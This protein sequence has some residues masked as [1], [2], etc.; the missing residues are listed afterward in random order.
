MKK[1]NNNFK[2]MVVV[3]VLPSLI[4]G[5]VEKGTLEVAKHLAMNGHNSIVI[6][7]GG[8][9]VNQLISDG[10]THIK[11]AI[12]KKSILTFFYII[13]LVAL[14]KNKN[15]ANKNEYFLLEKVSFFISRYTSPS[16]N[17]SSEISANPGTLA[18]PNNT[19]DETEIID[20]N[21]AA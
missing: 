16:I 15:I 1:N 8:R 9:L 7:N 19:A 4:S 5:G 18:P 13:R 10:S 2:K 17:G 6:S 12:G 3:Q 20:A 21:N 11:W 14:I